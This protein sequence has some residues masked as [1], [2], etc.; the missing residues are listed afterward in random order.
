MSFPSPGPGNGV[1]EPEDLFAS[2]KAGYLAL[3]ELLARYREY[4]I[5]IVR[6]DMSD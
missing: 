4:L 5:P 3:A 6:E 1:P 2:F